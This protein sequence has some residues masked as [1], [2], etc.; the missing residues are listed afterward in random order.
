MEFIENLPIQLPSD[1]EMKVLVELCRANKPMKPIEIVRYLGSQK[2]PGFETCL[3]VVS[4]K[5][6]RKDKTYD[7]R[8]NYLMKLNKSILARLEASGYIKR[9]KVGTNNL[10]KITEAGRFVANFSGEF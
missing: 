4:S 10:V 3:D 6:P 2:I 9:E 5:I 1:R 7:K 8:I